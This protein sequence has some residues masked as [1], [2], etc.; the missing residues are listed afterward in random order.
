MSAPED[1]T[2]GWKVGDR[3]RFTPRFGFDAHLHAGTIVEMK[4]SHGRDGRAAASFTV[5]VDPS[6][7][8][9]RVQLALPHLVRP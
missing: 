1:P 3:V 2:G 7:G 4:V 8:A 9:G 6:D 5:Q